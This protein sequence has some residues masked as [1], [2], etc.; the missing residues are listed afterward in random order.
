[1]PV[2]VEFRVPGFERHYLPGVETLAPTQVRCEDWFQGFCDRVTAAIGKRYL[3]V[4][5]IS[6]GEFL[7]LLG[8]QPLGRLWPWS[9]RAKAALRA[10]RNRLL[11]R[12]SFNAGGGA[13]GGRLYSSGSYTASEWR[14]ARENYGHL[15]GRISEEGILAIHLTHGTPLP[16]QQHYFPA[17][18]RWLAR[19]GVNLTLDNYVPFYLVYALLRGPR[20]SEILQGRR[21][22]VVHGASGEERARIIAG[23]QREGVADVQWVQIS[24]NRSLLDRVDCG[25]LLGSVDVCLVGAGV[26]KPNIL[27]Q[28]KPLGVPCL[29]AGYV[30]EAWADS[31]KARDRAFMIPDTDPAS[32]CL[33]HLSAAEKSAM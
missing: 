3:P 1:M 18:G 28:L 26:G 25:S 5:R 31:T 2:S 23:L 13:R 12:Q 27:V 21:V 4:C 32:A 14:E 6:D 9:T 22:A 8:P 24:S 17:F 10:L 7:F 11:D 20:K 33:K 16:F 30:F 29:D 19:E 15:L